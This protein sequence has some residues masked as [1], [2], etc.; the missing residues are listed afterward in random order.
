MLIH[1]LQ[2]AVFL[3]VYKAVM[4]SV[5]TVYAID[6]ARMLIGRGVR[7]VRRFTSRTT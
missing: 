2:D 7:W 5:F 3:G 4:A 6:L 1:A